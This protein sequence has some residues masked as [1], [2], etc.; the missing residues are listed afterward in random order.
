MFV[1]GL[2]CG[3]WTA[4]TS[5]AKA[6]G[7][8][9]SSIWLLAFGAAV[10]LLFFPLLQAGLVRD[11]VQGITSVLPGTAYSESKGS[12]LST[13]GLRLVAQ[14]RVWAILPALAVLWPLVAWPTRQSAINWSLLL[15]GAMAYLVITP[16]LRPYVFHAF[17]LIWT[18]TLGVVVAMVHEDPVERSW[19]WQ[20]RAVLL[21]VLAM[22][23]NVGDFP[24][25]CRKSLVQP[26]VRALMAHRPVA[27][28]PV[29]YKHPY[30]ETVVLPPWSDYQAALAY[31]R[32]ELAP[33]TRVAN[34]LNGIAVNGP[35]GRLPAFPAE[36]L[37]WIFVVRAAD[38]DRFITTLRSTPDSV[39]VWNPDATGATSVSTQFPRLAETIR[40]LY[41]PSAKFG[42]IA[43]WRRRAGTPTA[44][45]G[46]SGT[47]Q[48]QPVP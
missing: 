41:K 31:L 23:L 43:V 14:G 5:V 24:S 39:V 37:T 44:G 30:G 20:A 47:S 35:T 36:S 40:N 29:G 15:V 18:F 33:S 7:L 42:P 28:A 13:I 21:L 46:Q 17:W 11:L 2:L 9:R 22:I 48:Q 16:V 34:A 32:S 38:E 6:G 27:E 26:A 1:P 45:T 19:P 3:A 8:R 12:Q 10:V 4:G 25:T